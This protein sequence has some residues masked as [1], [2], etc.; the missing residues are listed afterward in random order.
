MKVDLTFV[1][2]WQ[3]LKGDSSRYVVIQINAPRVGVSFG[4]ITLDEH[5]QTV[6]V[7]NI[8]VVGKRASRSNLKGLPGS[9]RNDHQFQGVFASGN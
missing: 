8:E 7:S 9:I 5:T 1:R 4:T 3:V 6:I 2:L